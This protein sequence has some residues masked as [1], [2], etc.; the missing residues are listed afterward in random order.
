MIKIQKESS[1]I[2]IQDYYMDNLGIIINMYKRLEI[3][4]GM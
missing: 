2:M 1:N 3:C 4:L